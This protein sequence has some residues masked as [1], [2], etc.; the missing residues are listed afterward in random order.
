MDIFRVRIFLLNS[1]KIH[2]RVLI[3][4]LGKSCK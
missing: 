2:S 1:P 4:G 3:F